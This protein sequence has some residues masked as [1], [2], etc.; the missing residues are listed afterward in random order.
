MIKLSTCTYKIVTDVA[1]FVQDTHKMISRTWIVLKRE[2]DAWVEHC[3]NEFTYVSP[4]AQFPNL[5][6]EQLAN[7]ESKLIKE[8]LEYVY[9]H[10]LE[11][12]CLCTLMK[13][14]LILEQVTD[15]EQL[16]YESDISKLQESLQFTWI[17]VYAQLPNQPEP[18]DHTIEELKK[19][20]FSNY[21]N[22]LKAFKQDFSNDQPIVIATDAS[23]EGKY[24]NSAFVVYENDKRIA[25][26][27]QGGY[28]ATRLSINHAELGAIDA[29]IEW[30][31]HAPYYKAHLIVD[32][33]IANFARSKNT[34]LKKQA[35]A[36]MKKINDYNDFCRKLKVLDILKTDAREFL[37]IEKVKSHSGVKENT[38]ADSAARN[39]VVSM[40]SKKYRKQKSRT[41]KGRNLLK[42]WPL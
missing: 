20:L 37:T 5:T 12:V 22:D 2:N 30:L 39:A 41:K 21:V 23:Q 13:P 1:T 29:A 28:D 7:E 38:D 4:Y 8:I 18:T 24:L 11:R 36:I 40:Y 26:V 42:D 35:L 10:Q 19:E 25:K 16:V 15:I 33:N 6:N 31:K 34:G 32:C 14:D 17:G 27:K 9:N 3:V